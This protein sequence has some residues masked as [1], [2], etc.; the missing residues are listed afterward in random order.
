MDTKLMNTPVTNFEA[1]VGQARDCG[2]TQTFATA[3]EVNKALDEAD[4]CGGGGS[5]VSTFMCANGIRLSCSNET[6]PFKLDTSAVTNFGHM[7]GDCINLTT[8]PQ[9]NTSNGTSFNSMF[10]SCKKLPTIPQINT[11]NGTDFGFMFSDCSNLTAIP[12]IDTSKGTSFSG[13]F[14]SCTNLTTIPQ[15]DTSKGTSFGNMFHWCSNLHTI[16]QLDTSNGTDFRYMFNGCTNLTIIPQLNISKGTKFN[17]MFNN[18]PKLTDVSFTGSINASISFPSSPLNEDS[19]E[20]ILLACANTTNSTSKS[21]S[22]KS[23]TIIT[24]TEGTI[25]DLITTCTSKGWTISGLTLN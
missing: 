22:F 8:I 17:F 9:I 20:S 6:I 21:L 2:L 16:P 13:M 5:D 19:A 23:G 10:D 24:D 7:F 11:S 12:S 15:L 25:T 18:C 1:L 3:Y 14:G 4:C